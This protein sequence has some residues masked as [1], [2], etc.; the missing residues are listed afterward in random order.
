VDPL[1]G[2]KEFIKRNGEFT[3]NIALVQGGN[4]VFGGK[5]LTRGPVIFL[6][7]QMALAKIEKRPATEAFIRKNSGLDTTDYAVN[8]MLH[9]LIYPTNRL[10]PG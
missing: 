10:F 2:T 5:I 9:L 7:R 4:P 6:N 3:V 8:K 1:D